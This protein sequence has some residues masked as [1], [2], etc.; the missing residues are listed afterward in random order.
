[1]HAVTYDDPWAM[2]TSQRFL[3]FGAKDVPIRRGMLQHRVPRDSCHELGTQEIM[4][5]AGIAGVQACLQKLR[6]RRAGES[7]RKNLT[8]PSER[9]RAQRQVRRVH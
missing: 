7:S 9:V 5:V 1:M 3:G 8:R 4:F 2:S 6:S